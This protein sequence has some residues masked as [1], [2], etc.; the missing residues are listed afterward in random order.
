MQSLDLARLLNYTLAMV[1]SLSFHEA[2]H[3]FIA[4]LRGDDTAR[5]AGRLTINPLAHIDWLGTL[6]LP[7][8]GALTRLPVIGWAKPVPVNPR[9]FR[10]PRFDNMLVAAAGPISNLLLSTAA[11]MAVFFYGIYGREFIPKES[12]F[13]PLAELSEALIWVNVY[14]AVFNLIPI[15]PLDGATVFGI[16]LPP[17][18]AEKY[19]DVVAPYGVFL[20]IAIIA[21][22]GL[23][24]L[25]KLAQ[26]F[27]GLVILGLRT[28]AS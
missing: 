4:Y 5:D 1:L 16:L 26:G 9:N 10:Y 6:I 23:H 17:R 15:P 8:L 18:I 13:Y 14:L 7:I 12:F 21:S 22:G 28:V 20:L 2:A 27:V 19:H 25:P 3:A 11:I 24:W